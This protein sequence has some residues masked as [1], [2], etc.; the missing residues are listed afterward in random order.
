MLIK[1]AEQ[2]RGLRRLLLRADA[3]DQYRAT[4][5]AVRKK[6]LAYIFIAVTFFGESKKSVTSLLG[7]HS[8]KSSNDTRWVDIEEYYMPG[9]YSDKT[10]ADDM[11]IKTNSKTLKVK[12]FSKSGK[13]LPVGT[14]CQVTGWGLTTQDIRQ[15]TLQGAEVYILDRELCDCFYNPNHVIT[16]DML[17]ARSNKVKTTK[18][19]ACDGDSGGPLEYKIGFIGL[20]S[21]G[22]GCGNPKKP[23]VYSRFSKRHLDWIN[24]IIKHQ[25][26][27]MLAYCKDGMEAQLDK[28]ETVWTRPNMKSLKAKFRKSDYLSGLTSLLYFPLAP[29]VAPAMYKLQVTRSF[30][31]TAQIALQQQG[32]N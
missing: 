9:T 2:Q 20:V 21:G 29:A 8:L 27:P 23:G 13:D 30:T 16:Q 14:Q 6:T 11:L 31:S 10:K 3:T 1:R 7:A 12:A 17:C 22:S 32:I 24:K 19:D 4:L 28:W 5:I 18:A 15:D 26:P 25:T